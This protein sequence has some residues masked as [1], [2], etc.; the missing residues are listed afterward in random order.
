MENN[1]KDTNPLVSI[2][3]PV[4]NG[5]KYLEE[6]ISSILHQNYS[7]L[8]LLIID[9]GST[10]RSADISKKFQLEDSRVIYVRN[11]KNM[12]L[13][14]TLNKAIA[15][16]K[17]ELI[18]RI[19]SDDIWSSKD[20]LS[21]QVEYLASHPETVI[22][23]TFAKAINID[24]NDVYEL[25]CPI[26]D[27]QIRNNILIKNPF[28]HPSV[29]FRKKEAIQAGLFMANE[30]HVE[31]YGLWM[32]LGKFGKFANI[33]D[34]LMKYRVHPASVT[35]SNNLQQ[36]KNSLNLAKEHRNQ[37]PNFFRGYLK[38]VTKLALLQLFGIANINTVKKLLGR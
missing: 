20:K 14:G 12:G 35:Q 11:E 28:I 24:G 18:G 16:A 13:I 31:D 34:A 32:R 8:E 23:G 10:D 21:K 6:A 1:T 17:G 25:R 27:L 4:Y 30:K 37:Y 38:W 19:D 5:E 29:V 3:L 26:S 9:D 7:N 2:I 22:V 15:M 36:T 33:P